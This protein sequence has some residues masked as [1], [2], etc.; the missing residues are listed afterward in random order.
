[1]SSKRNLTIR[2]T[3]ILTPY[4]TFKS[5]RYLKWKLG[6]S[7]VW[8]F[9]QNIN[10]S[11]YVF[12]ISDQ[13]G[14]QTLCSRIPNCCGWPC[15]YICQHY[16]NRALFS[17]KWR[18]FI[19]ENVYLGRSWAPRE[20]IRCKQAHCTK[21]LLGVA[22]MFF[23]FDRGILKPYSWYLH[24]SQTILTNW[25]SHHST[26]ECCVIWIPGEPQTSCLLPGPTSS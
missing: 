3:Y 10:I 7:F 24:V 17:C 26:S 13:R 15:S 18:K 2:N 14:S 8:T 1:M 11:Q 23:F 20:P 19:W 9:T 4:G 12:E 21:L 6:F 5:V 16:D 22:L 25:Y